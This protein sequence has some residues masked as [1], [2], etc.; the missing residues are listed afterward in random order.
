MD[1]QTDIKVALINILTDHKICYTK[2]ELVNYS[3]NTDA[4]IIDIQTI[5]KLT[6]NIIPTGTKEEL[7]SVPVPSTQFTETRFAV[8]RKS[9]L[10]F[11]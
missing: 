2:E 11:W 9:S 3:V 10:I 5:T 8:P 7:V 6:L 4:A 1:I